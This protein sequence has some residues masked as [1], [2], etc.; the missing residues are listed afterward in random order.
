M[1]IGFLGIPKLEIN[2]FSS[3]HNVQTRLYM[4]YSKLVENQEMGGQ[5][6]ETLQADPRVQSLDGHMLSIGSSASRFETKTLAAWF[7]WAINEFGQEVAENHLNTFL[8]AKT[9]PVINTLWVLGI[10]LKNTIE[11]I[12]GVQIVPIG[13]MPISD[14]KEQYS[15]HTFGVLG[16]KLPKPKA[17]LVY[18]SEVEKAINSDETPDT[19][20]QNFWAE[21][22][23]LHEVALL[24]NAIDGISCIPYLST[25]YTLPEV[26]IGLF[27]GSG[28]GFVLYDIFGGSLSKF[29]ENELK[30]LNKLIVSFNQLTSKEKARMSLILSRLSQAKRRMQIEDKIL[31]LGIAL[32]MTL[33]DD[34][35]NN[36][37][38][39]L[40]FRLRG[41]WL[42]GK[43]NHER[44]DIY[45]QLR[46][47]Y[48]YRSQVAHS[49]ILCGN[50]NEKIK[51]VQD[52]FPEYT[53]IAE[54][55][56]RQIIHSKKVDWTKLILGIVPEE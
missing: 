45:R 54:R 34:N 7:L 20:D 29:N 31:D 42:I 33:L 35:K 4:Q 13:E 52:T 12:N 38:L 36:H 39:S 28:G 24:L 19:R 32:E 22:Q 16:Y 6:L 26:P 56:I 15:K 46:E 9:I 37:Q 44:Q 27:A 3:E 23:T 17:A 40:S 49:G 48:T 2:V 18:Q 10:E 30:E 5:V 14:Q 41:S 1:E 55:I 21:S 50:D 11:L 8:D 47:I 51:I 25:S 43:D 53:H